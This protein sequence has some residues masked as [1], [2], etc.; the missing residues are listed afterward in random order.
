MKTVKE[1]IKINNPKISVLMPVYNAEKYL[2]SAVDS[3]LAQSFQDFELICVDDGSNDNSLAI[4][5]NLAKKDNRIRVYKNP[6]NTGIGYTRSKLKSL[7]KSSYIAIMDSDDVMVN[8]RLEKQYNFLLQNPKVIVVGGQCITID[9]NNKV[10][11]KK[12]FPTDHKSIYNMMYTNMSV[13]QPTIMVNCNLVP[14]D[15]PWYDNSVSPVEDLDNLFRLF[16]YGEFANLPDVTLYYRVY[17]GS[18]SLKDPK[19]TFN[20]TQIVRKRAI[21]DYGYMPSNTSVFI[22][23]LQL[24]LLSVLPSMFVLPFY[25]TIKRLQFAFS[26]FSYNVPLVFQK[27]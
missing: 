10:S 11:G 6:H 13:Q 7:A 25:K 2:V 27:V 9:E 23:K 4:L 24:I 12:I 26:K 1:T 17:R 20:L 14:K 8:N 5:K 15:F 21:E 16:N 22:V 18:S 19:R 3:V